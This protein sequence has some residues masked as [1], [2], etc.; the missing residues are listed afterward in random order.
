MKEIVVGGEDKS[1]R[2]YID[3]TLDRFKTLMEEYKIKN[4]NKLFLITDDI[5]HNLY[6]DVIHKFK[7]DLGCEIFY[8][9]H[10][11]EN[12]NIQRVQEIYDF[13]INNKANR[14]SVII[15]FGGGLVGD[16][17]GFAASTYMRGVKFINIPTTLLSQ[18]DSCIGGKVGYNY[19]G[20]KN[21]IGNFYNPLFVY[22]CTGFLKT[23]KDKQFKDGLGE[24]IKY[25]LI[26]DKNLFNFINYNY[27]HIL[28]KESDKLLHII[29]ESLKIKADLVI[30]DYK[31]TG[32]R[33]ILNFGHT[34][35][36]G[37]EVS[38]DFNISHGEAV[39]LGMLVAIKL[40]EKKFMTPKTLYKSVEELLIKLGLPNTYKVDN[41]SS[42]MYAINHDKKNNEK[43]RF[44]LLEDIGKCKIKVEITEKEI[45]DALEGSIDRR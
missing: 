32:L 30:K 43:I 19:N 23:L 40:S 15:A 7:K 10:G 11:E 1:Y 42:F 24:L 18:I 26:K 4:G 8:F 13:L 27:K 14:S 33:N 3:N 20:I 36:H 37:I 16:L 21:A 6:R 41:Y 38:S 34:V 29:R 45:Y 12:K 2:V 25:G 39:A 28:E 9:N 44:V 5:V 22:V 35:G 17:V 31:D